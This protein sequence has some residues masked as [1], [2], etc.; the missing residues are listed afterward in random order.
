MTNL[1]NRLTF[2]DLFAGC[3]GL[4]LGLEKAGFKPVLYSELN[5]SAADSYQI[6]RK[7][8]IQYISDVHKIQSEDI[9]QYEGIDLVCGGPPCQGYS[10]IGI[11]RT[12]KVEK[13]R[14]T[15]NILYMEMIRVINLVKPRIFLFE[16][17]KGIL[18]GKWNASGKKGQIFEDVLGAFQEKL[19]ENYY[20]RW[21]KLKSSLYGIP[22]NRPRVFIVGIHKSIEATL[23][24]NNLIRSHKEVMGKGFGLED[25]FLPQPTKQNIAPGI[26]ELLGDL[27]D[28]NYMKNG[29]KTK[30]YLVNPQNKWQ[31]EMREKH[32]S[33]GKYMKIGETLTEQEYSRHKPS[34]IKKFKYMLANNGEILEKYKTKK[35][36]QRL[37]RPEWE[38][39]GPSITV[40]SLPDDYVHYSQPRILT[41][42]EWARLQMF[43]DWYKFEGKRTTGGNRRSG[44]PQSTADQIETPKYT[45]I[46][47][48]V[49]VE[50]ARQIGEHFKTLLD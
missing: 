41:V 19:G 49:P 34:T 8:Q 43:P 3:G 15:K 25:N 33:P 26:E 48:A 14:I 30:K 39:K 4:S 7:D 38:K 28:N 40:T 9:Q 45:Q 37:L 46:G 23:T 21:D 13:D 6:N 44:N 31:E 24:I 35:F 17:V 22:Q 36:S 47:N 20:I 11:R 27:V 12:H 5:Q 42:R 29:F 18:T 10:G 2:I 32:D 16:N 50:L 1:N